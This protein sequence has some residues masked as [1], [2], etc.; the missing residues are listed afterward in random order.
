MRHRL[1]A[2]F[3]ALTAFGSALPLRAQNPAAYLAGTV[4]DS[5]TRAP[6]AGAVVSLLDG[7]GKV[8]AR[9]LSNERGEYRIPL[10]AGDRR[11]RV[12]RI[13]FEPNDLPLISGTSRS[14]RFDVSL[15]ALA[16]M[17]RSV[18]V[19]GNASCPRRVD[20]PQA[21]GLWEQAQDGLLAT[22]VARQQNPAAVVRLIFQRVFYG[23]TNQERALQVRVDSSVDAISFVAARSAQD[24]ALHGFQRDSANRRTQFGPDAIVLLSDAFA[25]SYC[26][27]VDSGG[28][29]RLN[30]VGIHFTPAARRTDR[31]DI[32]GTLWID[33]VARELRDVDFRY[34][35][36]LAAAEQFKPGGRV[37]FVTMRNGIVLVDGWTIRS[38]NSVSVERMGIV[39]G[40]F[41]PTR[42]TTRSAVEIG[43]QLA[44]ATWPD[45][46]R[47][48]APLGALRARA[49]RADGRP[50][51]NTHVS[52]AGTPYRGVVDSS[53]IVTIRDL[54]PGPYAVEIAEPRLDTLHV[55]FPSPLLFRAVADSTTEGSFAVPTLAS[56]AK[57]ACITAHQ[58]VDDSASVIGRVMT[59]DGTPVADAT[60]TFAARAHGTDRRHPES[61]L[62]GVDGF[63]ESC[64]GWHPDDEIMLHVSR[65][66]AKE[67]SA[68]ATFDSRIA[69]VRV[70][71]DP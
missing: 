34:L 41:Q 4:R 7:T 48:T 70:N 56:F 14:E 20:A 59:A 36:V 39:H 24:F 29:L 62:T 26:F 22:V 53:G 63:F 69:V 40:V 23:A 35:G 64:K 54:L 44:R 1:T 8:S 10:G 5:V 42:Q 50:A 28:A 25:A 49:T 71:V 17:M 15:L 31:L 67:V 57:D 38:M 68:T 45:G 27:R 12:V 66:G 6:I 43:G 2:A 37:S 46:V 51:V 13:G 9:R 16:T 52:L 19:V 11:M 58:A 30:Q 65:D 33:T 47:W 55:T 60:V 21:L 18:R 3:L 32:D 61:M